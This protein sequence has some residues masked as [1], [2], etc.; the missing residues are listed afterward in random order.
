MIGENHAALDLYDTAHAAPTPHLVSE[1][2]N[3]DSPGAP[4]SDD[5][6]NS[7]IVSLLS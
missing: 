3:N 5:T 7:F 4:F 6:G 2:C 1:Q